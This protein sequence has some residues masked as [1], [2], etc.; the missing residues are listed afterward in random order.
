VAEAAGRLAPSCLRSEPRGHF[1]PDPGRQAR[2]GKGG[3]EDQKAPGLASREFEE[4]LA[5]AAVIGDALGLEPPLVPVRPSPPQAGLRR[6]V[7]E[8][9][10]IGNVAA[11]GRFLETIDEIE[12]EPA[13]EPLIDPGGIGEAVAEDPA[14]GADR[15]FDDPGDMVGAGREKKVEFGQRQPFLGTPVEQQ[16]TDRLRSRGAARLAGG[17][18]VDA[19]GTQAAPEKFELGRFSGPLAA[20]EGDEGRRPRTAGQDAPPTR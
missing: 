17:E 13:G 12:T 6:Q 3:V 9:R 5:N 7:Q 19:R 14:A 8:H 20:L 4:S 10:Q 16:V 15:R 11:E 1:P 2:Y 18:T